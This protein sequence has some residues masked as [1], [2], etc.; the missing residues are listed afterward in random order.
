MLH[1]CQCK[2]DIQ[3]MRF[4]VDLGI[5]KKLKMVHF[6]YSKSQGRVRRGSIKNNRI[7]S[8]K[9]AILNSL[10]A[11]EMPFTAELACKLLRKSFRVGTQTRG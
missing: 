3:S 11:I 6:P 5:G 10:P 9:V 8:A 4:V 7:L 2:Q 1:L